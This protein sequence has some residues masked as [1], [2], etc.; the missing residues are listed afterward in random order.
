MAILA[1]R[2]P[3]FQPAMRVIDAITNAFPAVVTTSFP[4]QYQTGM[5]VRLNIPLGFGMQEANQKQGEIIV[6]TDTIFSVDIDTRYMD[7]YVVSVTYPQSYQSG[8]VTS[9]AENNQFLRSA[10]RNVLPY[11]S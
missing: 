9:I 7:P 11:N 2:F 3:T 1:V 10:M 6:L 4:H 8:Q 5:I